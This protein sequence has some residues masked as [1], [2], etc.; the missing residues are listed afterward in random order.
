MN[1]TCHCIGLYALFNGQRDFCEA[2]YEPCPIPPGCFVIRVTP[3][4]LNALRNK[5]AVPEFERGE[6]MIRFKDQDLQHDAWRSAN[7]ALP[8]AK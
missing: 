6:W 8:S 2:Y 4:E 7:H 5:Q 3:Y 1:E